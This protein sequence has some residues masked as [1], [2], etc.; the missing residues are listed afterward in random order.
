MFAMCGTDSLLLDG[1][2]ED[3]FRNDEAKSSWI[4]LLEQF[5]AA[6]NIS[7]LWSESELTVWSSKRTINNKESLYHH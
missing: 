7:V 2:S 3:P 5:V 4:W 1:E 6:V